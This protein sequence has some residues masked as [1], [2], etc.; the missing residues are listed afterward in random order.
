M[1]NKTKEQFSVRMTPENA[2][3]LH[4]KAGNYRG[5]VSELI[6]LAVHEMR[7]G[8]EWRKELRKRKQKKGKA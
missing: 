6:N 4:T 7:V 2:E 8:M 5:R 3:W 1:S